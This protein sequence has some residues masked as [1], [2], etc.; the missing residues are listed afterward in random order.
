MEERRDP[1]AEGGTRKAYAARCR[2]VRLRPEEAVL[3]G[4]K[5]PTSRPQREPVPERDRPTLLRPGFLI[6]SA[7]GPA[8]PRHGGPE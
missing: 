1:G 5:G 8:D 4:C 7:G 2:V 6:L 3:G